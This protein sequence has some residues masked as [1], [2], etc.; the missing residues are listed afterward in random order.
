MK[1]EG[2]EIALFASL[3]QLPF[4]SF[5]SFV[6]IL[7]IISFF[8]TSADSATVVLGMQSSNGI[9]N[10]PN[11]VKLLW[12]VIQSGLAALLLFIGGLDALQRTSIIPAFPFMIVLLLIITSL[13][14]SLK[15]EKI[16]Q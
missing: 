4:Y 8:I 16:P 12:G 15:S 2:N 9:L 5:L 10:P 11:R 14:K 3:E 13:A 6:A 7:L 1:I